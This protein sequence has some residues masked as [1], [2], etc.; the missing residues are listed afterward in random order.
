MRCYDAGRRSEING[1]QTADTGTVS[2]GGAAPVMCLGA[3]SVR[4]LLLQSGGAVRIPEPGDEAVVIRLSDGTAFV[5]GVPVYTVPDGFENGDVYL[6]AGNAQ[7]RLSKTGGI[8]ISGDVKISGSF[9]L[10]GGT[11]NGT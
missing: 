5:L 6:S 1:A 10:N 3:E 7:I 9:S 8:E 4:A 11:V 2:I